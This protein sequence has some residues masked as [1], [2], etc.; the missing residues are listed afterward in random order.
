M[1]IEFDES[2]LTGNNTIDTQH[3]ELIERIA[4]FV[5]ACEEGNGKIKAIKMMDYLTEYTEFHFSEEEKLQQ[6]A[7]YPGYEEH[8]AKHEELK[9]TVKALHE[10]LEELEWPTAAFVEKVKEQVLNWFLKH[11]DG[12]DRAIVEYIN[13]A[14]YS[15][16][17][18]KDSL[19]EKNT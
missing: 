19:E 5:S 10:F 18:E 8:K 4:V 3:R 13:S 17:T 15:E 16:L 9:K 12:D 11:I 14:N 1:M 2:L 7:G 6:D